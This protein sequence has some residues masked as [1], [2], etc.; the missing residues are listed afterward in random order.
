MIDLKTIRLIFSFTFILLYSIYIPV[1][2]HPSYGLIVTKEGDLYFCDVLHNSGTI[3][4]YSDSGRLEKILTNVHSHYLFIDSKGLIWGT[5]HDYIPSSG[6][7]D[8][9]LWNLNSENKKNIVI[10]AT[11]DPREFSGVNFV[12]DKNEVVYF[13]CENYIYKR[14]INSSSLLFADYEFERI[15]SL[16]MDSKGNIYVVDNNIN[17]GSVFK[18]KK[19]G[20]TELIKGNLL[21]D[22]PADPPLPDLMHNMLYASFVDINGNIFIANSGSRRISRIDINGSVSHIYHSNTPW[23]PVAYVKYGEIEY[24]METGFQNNENIGPR[25]IRRLNG[26][27]EILI[28]LE[29]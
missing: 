3:W 9:V 21:E 15:M 25:I 22:D 7:N 29:Q 26:Q 6:K 8:N 28:E 23:Y 2:A 27:K 4:K 5:D 13:D 10:P 18:I 17:T 24:I 16:Q 12:V 14:D 11:S 20:H 1:S 19:T